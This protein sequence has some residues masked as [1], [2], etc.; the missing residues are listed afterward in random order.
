MGVVS[1]L[2]SPS[3]DLG[4]G[5]IILLLLKQKSFIYKGFVCYGTNVVQVNWD[6][7]YSVFD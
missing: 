3:G 1:Y 5:S 7:K 4:V 6:L 2:K